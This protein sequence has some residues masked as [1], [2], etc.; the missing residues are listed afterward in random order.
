MT[1]E[2][3]WKTLDITKDVILGACGGVVS[4]L[5][6]Y[7]KAN[8]NGNTTFVF[9]FSYLL[10]N[11]VLGMFVS[12]SV[13]MFVPIDVLGRDAYIGLAGF[14]AF[15]I[16]VIAESRA[17]IYLFEAADRLLGSKSNNKEGDIK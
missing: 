11:M 9:K 12:Y 6:D 4:Y 1:I 13:G 3:V 10:V 15:S 7:R 17:A 8:K 14:S 2:D 16:L 5:F